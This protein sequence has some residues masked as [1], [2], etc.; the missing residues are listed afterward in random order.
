MPGHTDETTEHKDIF[1]FSCLLFMLIGPINKDPDNREKYLAPYFFILPYLTDRFI[2]YYQQ[3]KNRAEGLHQTLLPSNS[4]NLQAPLTLYQQRLLAAYSGTSFL[5]LYMPPVVIASNQIN[6]K[7][8]LP[9]INFSLFI[10]FC[11]GIKRLQHAG[12]GKDKEW[13]FPFLGLGVIGLIEEVFAPPHLKTFSNSALSSIF[14]GFL[15]VYLI[16]RYVV[17]PYVEKYETQDHQIVDGEEPADKTQPSKDKPRLSNQL[18]ST[19]FEL[20]KALNRPNLAG[21]VILSKDIRAYYRNKDDMVELLKLLD[22]DKELTLTL[23]IGA[24]KQQLVGLL[25]TEYGMNIFKR[26]RLFSSLDNKDL[27]KLI[28]D[29]INKLQ[30]DSLSNIIQEMSL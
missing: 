2:I 20:E 5:C 23:E 25:S 30:T 3:K 21:E 16:C 4:L 14:L 7:I 22:D 11:A 1:F 18:Y 27:D 15:S 6:L 9:T 19:V 28:A 13:L 29:T 10:A 24:V 12:Y 26:Y 17:Y 8:K